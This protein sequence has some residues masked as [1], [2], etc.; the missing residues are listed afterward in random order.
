MENTA[1]KKARHPADA[2]C[3][4]CDFGRAPLDLVLDLQKSVNEVWEKTQ[5]MVEKYEQFIEQCGELN[6]IVT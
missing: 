3:A 4:R 6:Y 5:M 1:G 2:E